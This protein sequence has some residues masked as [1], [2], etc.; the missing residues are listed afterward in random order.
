MSR[1]V[2]NNSYQA[3]DQDDI[4]MDGTMDGEE[5]QSIRNGA[6]NI[7][8]RILEGLASSLNHLRAFLLE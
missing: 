8:I 6:L 5:V 1:H 2:T 7:L 4:N 3:N